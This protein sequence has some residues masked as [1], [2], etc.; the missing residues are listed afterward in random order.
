MI[1]ML[2]KRDPEELDRRSERRA[3]IDELPA[4]TLASVWMDIDATTGSLDLGNSPISGIEEAIAH[5]I[6]AIE[7][8]LNSL[9]AQTGSDN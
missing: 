3:E 5:H 6:N 1:D 7:A 8:W 2:E 4:G 9:V